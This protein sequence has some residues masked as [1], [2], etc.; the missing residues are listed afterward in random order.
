MIAR[1]ALRATGTLNRMQPFNG[2]GWQQMRHFSIGIALAAAAFIALAAPL[3]ARADITIEAGNHPQTGEQNILLNNGTT[4][5]TVV[6]VTN[7]SG[8]KV[9]FTSNTQTLTEPANGQARIE[10]VG[11]NG[12]QVALSDVSSIALATGNY[13]D[14]IFDSHIGGTI[15][16]SG[17]TETVTVTD[18]MGK[19][20]TASFTLGN[21]ENFVTIFATNGESIASTSISYPD[22]F[23]DLRQVRIST[24]AP[25]P[26]PGS[27]V[28]AGTGV[29][30]VL[31]VFGWRR[32]RSRRV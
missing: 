24:L 16:T 26:E 19:T 11:A 25:V 28:L 14:L 1:E 6:G 20:T 5:S 18:N 2:G 8:E 3:S 32:L 30:G 4:G 21:G 17:G 23:T 22:G 12:G 27:V 10:A 29:A 15:G 9:D 31:T 13:H 7:Q